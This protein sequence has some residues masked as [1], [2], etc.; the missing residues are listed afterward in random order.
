MFWVRPFL[1]QTQTVYVRTRI[2]LVAW[3]AAPTSAA[4]GGGGFRVGD[5]LGHVLSSWVC[6]ALL[7]SSFVY[8]PLPKYSRAV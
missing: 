8:A 6:L 5:L 7:F 3:A 4:Q 1:S 2:P